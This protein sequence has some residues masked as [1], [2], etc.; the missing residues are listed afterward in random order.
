MTVKLT[1][2]MDKEV[3]EKAK[4][5]SRRRGKS[6][7]RMAE[8]HFRALA[9]A[10]GVKRSSVKAMSGVLEGKMAPGV[11]LKVAKGNYLKAKYGL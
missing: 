7:S 9:E 3:I 5:I 8:E 6:L 1:L 10:D 4:D 11:T 2:S